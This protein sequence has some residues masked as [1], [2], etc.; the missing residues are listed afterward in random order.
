M[1][2]VTFDQMMIWAPYSSLGQMEGLL[3]LIGSL[4]IHDGE[5]H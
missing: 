5:L 4:T 1:L 3:Y 2:C